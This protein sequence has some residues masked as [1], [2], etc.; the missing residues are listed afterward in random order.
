MSITIDPDGTVGSAMV[1]CD[2]SPEVLD[3]LFA[4]FKNWRGLSRMNESYLHMLH[5]HSLQESDPRGSA[6]LLRGV[7]VWRF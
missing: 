6:G 2:D 5:G 4:A 7:T 3:S 1:Q